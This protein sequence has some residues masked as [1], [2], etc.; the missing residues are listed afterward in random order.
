MKAIVM[1]GGTPTP[2]DPLYPYTQGKP[3]ALLDIA[4]QPMLQ[5]VL[6]AINQAHHI[7]E[8]LIFGTDA[9]AYPW[10]L[11]KPVRWRP[12]KG[13]MVKNI[14][15]GLEEISYD[16][17][18]DAWVMLISGDVPTVTGH[19]LDWVATNAQHFP[20]VDVIYHVVTRD[21]MEKR[22]PGVRRTYLRLRDVEVCGADVNL[23]R[24]RVGQR[25]DDLWERLYAARKSPL[26][27]AA[28]IGWGTLLKILLRRLTLAEAVAEVSQRLNLP[29]I[30]VLAPYAEIAMDV[31]KPEHVD[32]VRRELAQH[33]E[34][35]T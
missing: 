34:V 32:I 4:G 31:D 15:S 20:T 30:A 7:D 26:K 14:L 6:D 3:K 21:I 10:R 11:Q 16:T 1:A 22:F 29:G 9:Q 35:E 13:S 12:D 28:L 19:I 5:W 8:I 33:R 24:V 23:V 27:Q 18:Q 2:D 17:P 25:G